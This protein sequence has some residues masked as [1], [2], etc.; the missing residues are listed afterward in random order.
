MSSTFKAI[1]WCHFLGTTRTYLATMGGIKLFLTGSRKLKLPWNTCRNRKLLPEDSIRFYILVNPPLPGY[2]KPKSEFYVCCIF[3]DTLDIEDTSFC[4]QRP[5]YL[6]KLG[7]QIWFLET[8]WWSIW[9]P[10]LLL[11]SFLLSVSYLFF[12]I[13]NSLVGPP[14][15]VVVFEVH[16][17]TLNIKVEIWL[18]GSCGPNSL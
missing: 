13:H 7:V 6:T 11:I 10:A 15:G 3:V 1:L 17:K 5:R 9:R 16:H 18:R 12:I 2:M 4:Q 8:N 14:L